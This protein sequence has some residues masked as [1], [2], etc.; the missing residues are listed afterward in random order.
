MYQV[1]H[2][3][4]IAAIN[5][6]NS[7]VNNNLEYILTILDLNTLATTEAI[8]I[9]IDSVLPY[10]INERIDLIDSLYYNV[11]AID[12]FLLWYNAYS[13]RKL[14]VDNPTNHI[15]SQYII[16]IRRSRYITGFKLVDTHHKYVNRDDSE[17]LEVIDT[18]TDLTLDYIIQ[19]SS[20]V[21]HDI[22]NNVLYK[23]LPKT[24][25]PMYALALRT[26]QH[27]RY[28]TSIIP[29]L[30]NMLLYIP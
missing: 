10:K 27:E 20:E 5:D 26:F 3:D 8:Y 16:N 17:I 24:F 18:I 2:N 29:Y 6:Y 23:E 9:P 30:Y 7:G 12:Y 1:T 11:V 19:P 28:Y 21:V 15:E 14:V 22:M 13:N 25:L 4:M